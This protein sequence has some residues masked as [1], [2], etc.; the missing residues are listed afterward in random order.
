MARYETHQAAFALQEFEVLLSSM[1]RNV[2]IYLNF[3]AQNSDHAKYLNQRGTH[4]FITHSK[5]GSIFR[6][7]KE[8][9]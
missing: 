8:A 5:T 6:S 2:D 1:F 9:R 3:A 4:A 7:S